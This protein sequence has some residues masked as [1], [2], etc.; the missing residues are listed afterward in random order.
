MAQ[1]KQYLTVKDVADQLQTSEYTVRAL[2]RSGEL[3]G[4]KVAK[5][6][7]TTADLLKQYVEGTGQPQDGEK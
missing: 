6:W 1:G 2:F 4:R 5:K 7:M 3:K